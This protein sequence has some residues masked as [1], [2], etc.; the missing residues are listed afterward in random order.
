VRGGCPDTKVSH[1]TPN[2]HILLVEL[3]DFLYTPK[4]L[5]STFSACV[6]TPYWLKAVKQP[7]RCLP[8]DTP[9]IPNPTATDPS[10]VGRFVLELVDPPMVTTRFVLASGTQTNLS[11]SPMLFSRP[12]RQR[13]STLSSSPPSVVNSDPKWMVHGKCVS[14]QRLWCICF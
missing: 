8:N 7:M 10:R 13:Q 11:P 4:T 14:R 3:S 6:T 1:S 5:T 12:M 2:V 9:S